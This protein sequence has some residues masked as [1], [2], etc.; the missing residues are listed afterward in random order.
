MKIA[1]TI[2]GAALL[3]THPVLGQ[4]D[5]SALET[6]LHGKPLGLRTYSADPVT[7]YTWLN[8]KLVP[9]AIQMHGIEA[10]FSDTV[11]QKGS[12][13]TI[14]G[15]S[16][17][18]VRNEGKLAPMGRVP[19]R[20]EVDLQGADAATVIPQL[21]AALFFPNMQAAL[22]GLPEFVSD[23]L[24]FPADGKVPTTCRCSHIFQDGKWVKLE[25]NDPKLK[26]P[27]FIKMASNPGL[28]QMAIDAK[29]SGTITLIYFVND[30]GRVDEVWLAKPLAPGV[31]ASA[32]KSGRENLLRPATYDG[33]PVG[34]VL[35]QTISAN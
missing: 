22:N 1:T 34:T 8:G 29:V 33:K 10:F 30:I 6:A 24:P 26:G 35:V 11:R 5:V 17:I 2:L 9:G 19:M 25:E 15:Q 32:A 16:S 18:L 3:L 28:T 21:Q 14:D 31:D 23:M 7:T 27:T 12:K 20:L 13:I 4:G